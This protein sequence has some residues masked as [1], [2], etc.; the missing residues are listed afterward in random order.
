[1]KSGMSSSGHSTSTMGIFVTIPSTVMTLMQTYMTS[2]KSLHSES[3]YSVS[4][5][6]ASFPVSFTSHGRLGSPLSFGMSMTTV[7]TA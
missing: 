6:T 3:S 5:C 1:M 2:N 4:L 7:K